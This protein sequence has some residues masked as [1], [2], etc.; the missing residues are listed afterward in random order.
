M[1]AGAAGAAE[2]KT[3]T[4]FRLGRRTPIDASLPGLRR[5][6]AEPDVFV[7]DGFLSDAACDALVEQARGK[8]V[9]RSPVAY[10]GWTQDA[11]AA[12]RLCAG[13]PAAWAAF[14][15]LNAALNANVAGELGVGGVVAGVVGAWAKGMAVCTVGVAGWLGWRYAGLREQR[16]SE[17]TT[18]YEGAGEAMVVAC[19]RLL[20][21]GRSRFEATTVIR[22]GQGSRLAPHFDANRAASAEDGA[23]GG[24]TLATVLC[25][26][27]DVPEGA[28]GRTRFGRLGLDVD[29][30]KGQAL[31]FFPADAAGAFDE[32]V[33]HEGEA[34]TGEGGAEKWVARIW[35]HQDSVPYPYGLK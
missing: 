9:E 8:G 26:L 34:F 28:G 12:L 29:P 5:V 31:L 27:N 35:M 17:S 16:T 1:R 14:P 25:Y 3:K 7:V 33:E 20:C 6:H 23:R 10:A 24:Q 22:Y 18:L 13:G 15:A 11:A 4:S 30:R 32:R 2:A 21:S 19:E